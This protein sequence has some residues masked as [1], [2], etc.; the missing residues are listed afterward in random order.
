MSRSKVLLKI[1]SLFSVLVLTQACLYEYV[2]VDGNEM[3]S[4]TVGGHSKDI[5]VT[6]PGYC[7]TKTEE[8]IEPGRTI[9]RKEV[10]LKRHSQTVI[11]K[12]ACDGVEI[13]RKKEEVKKPYEH[14]YVYSDTLKQKE[15]DST[16]GYNYTSCA[17][18]TGLIL[19][20]GSR[21]DDDSAEFKF[22]ADQAR[23]TI[24]S[25]HVLVGDN[26]IEYEFYGKCPDGGDECH[27]SQRPVLEKA[28]LVLTVNYEVRDLDKEGAEP[29]VVE[30]SCEN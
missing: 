2:Y 9:K 20:F 25:T 21:P 22:T 26:I 27:R 29:E 16:Y 19:R 23:G 17:Q 13:S 8:D 28:A 10:L 12:R 3:A 18:T 15:V 14:I 1:A 5:P 6:G 24:F 7:Q 30:V 11:R 4:M